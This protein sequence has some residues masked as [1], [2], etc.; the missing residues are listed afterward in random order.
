MRGNTRA[1]SLRDFDQPK[2]LEDPKRLPEADSHLPDHLVLRRR[3]GA[4]ASFPP[5]MY[6][7]NAMTACST[8]RA[9][10][11]CL[12]LVSSI[13][14]LRASSPPVKRASPCPEP[15]PVRQSLSGM[16][17]SHIRLPCA[18]RGTVGFSLQAAEPRT[19]IGL[20]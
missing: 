6:S 16:E 13:F 8:M 9:F 3:L 4:G 7:F 17:D 5:S 1:P 14:I 20:P 10:S 19:R 11:P 15:A 2:D 12:R 18:V